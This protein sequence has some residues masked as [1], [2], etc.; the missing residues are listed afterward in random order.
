MAREEGQ[1]EEEV[2]R[3]EEEEEDRSTG[4]G[5]S[6]SMTG[7]PLQGLTPPRRLTREE[8]LQVRDCI[9]AKAQQTGLQEAVVGRG[10]DW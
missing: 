9:T 2:E 1:R 3:E 8:A 10:L 7:Y 4:S 6:D 5:S